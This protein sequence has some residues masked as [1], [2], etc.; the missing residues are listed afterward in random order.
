MTYPSHDL[1]HQYCLSLRFSRLGQWWLQESECVMRFFVADG[2]ED[3][4]EPA[5][6]PTSAAQ[7]P[8]RKC[9]ETSQGGEGA[10][11]ISGCGA[12]RGGSGA[13]ARD[14]HCSG[15]TFAARSKLLPVDSG[16]AM[17]AV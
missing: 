5:Q 6:A 1:Q 11:L 13:G 10:H 2:P 7:P 8:Q 3:E 4:E 12:G 9:S 15:R 14:G 17:F 16:A